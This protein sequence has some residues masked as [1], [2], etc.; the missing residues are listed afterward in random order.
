MGSK[1]S[2]CYDV[3]LDFVKTEKARNLIVGGFNLGK[4][5]LRGSW[6]NFGVRVECIQI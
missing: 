3:L 4:I 5:A 6:N 1:M 2:D